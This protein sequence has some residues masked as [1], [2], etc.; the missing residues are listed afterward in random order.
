MVNTDVM[1]LPIVLT[2]HW[3]MTASHIMHILDI[4]LMNQI[5][6]C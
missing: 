6:A 5:N 2:I 3:A 1:I 4:L